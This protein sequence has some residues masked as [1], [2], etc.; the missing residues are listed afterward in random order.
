MSETEK[1]EKTKMMK[2]YEENSE[3]VKSRNLDYYYKNK[4]EIRQKLREKILCP[5]CEAVISKGNKIRH[6]KN[7]K[8]KLN[9]EIRAKKHQE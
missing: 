9:Q 8:C 2:Y 7:P 6:M 4:E 1:P 3:K 5:K